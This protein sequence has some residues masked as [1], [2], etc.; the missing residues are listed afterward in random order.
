MD[1]VEAFAAGGDDAARVKAANPALS[2]TVGSGVQLLSA[3]A[4]GLLSADVDV[5]KTGQALFQS[6]GALHDFRLVLSAGVCAAAFAVLMKKGEPGSVER[7]A[8][9]AALLLSAVSARGAHERGR[10]GG[11]APRGLDVG[12]GVAGGGGG[13]CC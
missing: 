13:F 3:A 6:V 1:A 8:I 7:E 4:L 9:E 11:R 5:E 12:G 2:F 10:R